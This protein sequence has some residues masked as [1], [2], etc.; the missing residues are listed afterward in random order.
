[1]VY[2]MFFLKKSTLKLGDPNIGTILWVVNSP[3]DRLG[4]C[5]WEIIVV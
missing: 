5:R 3:E 2:A 1:M 4:T